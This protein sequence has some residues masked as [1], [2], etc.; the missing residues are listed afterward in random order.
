VLKRT[1]MP[2][3]PMMGPPPAESAEDGPAAEKPAAQTEEAA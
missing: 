3:N 1:E 2:A